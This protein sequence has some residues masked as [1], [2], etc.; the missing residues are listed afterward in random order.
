MIE[1]KSIEEIERIEKLYPLALRLSGASKTQ[2]I[3]WFVSW[4]INNPD[5]K[6]RIR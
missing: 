1:E 2:I 5:N 6:V 3:L 4:Q